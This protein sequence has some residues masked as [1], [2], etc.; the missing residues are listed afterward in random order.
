MS[1]DLR[2]QALHADGIASSRCLQGADVVQGAAPDVGRGR[3]PAGP[4]R[5]KKLLQEAF[6]EKL[7][8]IIEEEGSQKGQRIA[9][10]LADLSWEWV[11]KAKTVSEFSSP[12]SITSASA[13]CGTVA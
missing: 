3:D 5:R 1:G 10:A 7:E 8:E 9:Q 4:P 12:S 2:V 11:K 6:K 13:I